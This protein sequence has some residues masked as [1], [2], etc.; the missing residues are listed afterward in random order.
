MATGPHPTLPFS[1]GESDWTSQADGTVFRDFSGRPAIQYGIDHHE[2]KTGQPYLGFYF[3][4][5]G[6]QGEKLAHKI[7]AQLYGRHHFIEV[8]A[9]DNLSVELLDRTYLAVVFRLAQPP[10]PEQAQDRWHAIEIFPEFQARHVEGL[11]TGHYQLQWRDWNADHAASLAPPGVRQD[12]SDL[13]ELDL[14]NGRA[15]AS[16]IAPPVAADSNGRALPCTLWR[17]APGGDDLYVQI[18]DNLRWLSGV[19]YNAST[20]VGRNIGVPL[21]HVLYGFADHDR[22]AHA[23]LADVYRRLGPGE[24][25]G[26]LVYVADHGDSPITGSTPGQRLYLILKQD[27]FWIATSPLDAGWPPLLDLRSLS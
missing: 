5:R 8:D 24:H 22:I 16:S 10:L 18:F 20:A 17:G 1:K 14:R 7:Y 6:P 25:T 3:V 23:C 4:P 27:P 11:S 26:W 21:A 13:R 2:P 19:T 15:S 9:A 12:D